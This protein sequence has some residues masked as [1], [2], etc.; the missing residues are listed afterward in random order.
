MLEGAGDLGIGAAVIFF[1]VDIESYLGGMKINTATSWSRENCKLDSSTLGSNHAASTGR[2][3][4]F[5]GIPVLLSV[6]TP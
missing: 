6:V 5:V 1:I 2:N 3:T 4:K